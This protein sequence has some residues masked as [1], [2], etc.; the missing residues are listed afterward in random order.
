MRTKW[1]KII[2]SLIIFRT[3]YNQNEALRPK[4]NITQ[5]TI[6]GSY[7]ILHIQLYI[8][9]VFFVAIIE[10]KMFLYDFICLRNNNWNS[11]CNLLSFGQREILHKQTVIRYI[12]CF[13]NTTTI[14]I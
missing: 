12:N 3:A 4:N 7:M 6:K 10:T 5:I 8:V 9:F 13:E 2:L 11:H 1:L 14:V